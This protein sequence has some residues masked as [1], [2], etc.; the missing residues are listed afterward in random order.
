MGWFI[1]RR[2]LISIPIVFGVTVILFAILQLSPG[3]PLGVYAANPN[4]SP[5]VRARIVA[6]YGLDQPLPVQYLQWV[7]GLVRGDW[8]TSFLENRPVTE[9][10]VERLPVTLR[11]MGLSFLIGLLISIP[12]GVIS[13][14]RHRSI[15]GAIVGPLTLVGVSI[16]PFFSGLILIII[17]GVKLGW[18]PFVY[19]TEPRGF[20]DD[21]RQLVLPL[22][23]L[24]L[25]QVGVMTRFVRSAMLE[26]LAQD[27]LR[28]GRAKGLS[29]RTIVFSH[30]FRNAAIPLVTLIALNIPAVFTGAI[31]VEQLFSI[32]GI[33]R[34]LINSVLSSDYLVVMAIVLVF[35]ILTVLCNLL[36]DITYVL[37]DPRITYA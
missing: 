28:T 27:Y 11:V 3:D 23:V 14:V 20:I 34:L 8:G 7:E 18:L 35:A 36:A 21:V 9:V 22:A 31:I 32:P 12:L 16:P 2:L 19:S 37:L 15:S 4:L 17:F 5:E 25:Y 29:E 33:G 26:V 10:V 30:A 13:A 1:A 24:S 6:H